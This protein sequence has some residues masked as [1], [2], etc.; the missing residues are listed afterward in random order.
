MTKENPAKKKVSVRLPADLRAELARLAQRDGR[1]VS[2]LLCRWTEARI[3]AE[4][5]RKTA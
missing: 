2:N 4:L 5:Q 1:T 3:R